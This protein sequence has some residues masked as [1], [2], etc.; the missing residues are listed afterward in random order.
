MQGFGEKFWRV[1]GGF[2]VICDEWWVEVGLT[3][4]MD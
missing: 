3:R 4:F 2:C 1:S